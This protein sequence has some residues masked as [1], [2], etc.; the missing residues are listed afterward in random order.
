MKGGGTLFREFAWAEILEA[1]SM[2]V[3]LSVGCKSCVCVYIYIYIER[4]RERILPMCVREIF[5]NCVRQC[6]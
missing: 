6:V 5:R 2:G 3:M 1:K 4:E